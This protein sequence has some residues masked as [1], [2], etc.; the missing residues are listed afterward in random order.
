[1]VVKSQKEKEMG[2]TYQNGHGVSFVVNENVLE[3]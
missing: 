2:S 1:V 3:L